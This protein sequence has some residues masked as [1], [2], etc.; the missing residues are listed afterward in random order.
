MKVA[1][2]GTGYV[3]LSTGVCLAEIG[4]Q[5]RC[6]DIDK[7]KIN[8]LRSGISPIYE[9]GI[10]NMLTSNIEAGRLKFTTSH[11]KGLKDIDIIIVAVGTPQG[12]DGAADLKYLEQAALD[13]SEHLKHDAIVVIKSTV[14]VGTND[15]IKKIIRKHCK[16]GL[17][18]EVVSN[19]EFLRQGTAIMDT[20][21]AE[22]III[23][24][25]N[26]EA[27]EKVKELYIA[28]KVPI[29][30]TSIRSAEMIKYAS[31][32]FLASKIS[33]INEISTLCEAVGAD[34]ID[35]AL[36]MGKDYRIGESFLQAGIGYGGSCF[37]KDV[38]ALLYTAHQ[39]EIDF[40]LLKETISINE[41]Q[42]E[43]LV[44]K[45]LKRF[46]DL[47]GKKIAMLGL[48]FKPDT[49]DMREAPSIKIAQLLNNLGAE[50]RAY[51]P[52]AVDN[53]KKIMGDS[54]VY[55]NSVAEAVKDTDALFIV[56]EWNEFKQL[57][58]SLVTNLMNRP[59]IF[60]GRNCM[61]EDKVRACKPIEYYPIG[62][63]MIVIK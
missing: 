14:P 48:A 25:E 30:F 38:K 34:V 45:A 36:G 16:K 15:N 28:L 46:G 5:V 55:A 35:V 54:I 37:P 8:K 43:I 33:F 63:P 62:R 59:I 61:E 19:P 50:V 22:R 60:D 21:H 17:S 26:I 20:M 40:S 11:R 7:Q 39:Y 47:K 52:V 13:I 18:I 23:G 3:G 24:S 51:D 4:H 1:V 9:P 42:K 56:T 27:A 2:I 49:D 31:N 57:D 29:L 44:T 41:H 58:L 6:I 32:A 12:E 53:A 10:E